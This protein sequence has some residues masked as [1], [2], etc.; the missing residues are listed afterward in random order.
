MTDSTAALRRSLE[1]RFKNASRT[2]GQPSSQIRRRFFHQCYLAR[3]FTLPG[4]DWVLKGGV[5]LAVR[6]SNARH[7]IDIDLYRQGARDELG[8][9]IEQLITA[10]GPS[11]RDPF[12]FEV[13]RKN[14]IIGAAGGTTLTVKCLL[15]TR[16]LDTFPIDLTTRDHTVGQL[17]E[18]T[19]E[20]LVQIPQVMPPPP[21]LV[22]PLADQIADKLAAMY[23][24]HAQGHPSSRYRDLVDLVLI[25]LDDQSIDIHELHRAVTTQQALRNVTIPTPL[26]APGQEWNEQY[27]KLSSSTPGIPQRL[28]RL[29][30]AL[31]H[32]SHHLHD[33][34]LPEQHL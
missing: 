33:A 28:R 12:I 32:V 27:H 22:Y 7:S 26:T 34:L 2:T 31:A 24:I 11:K 21:M 20:H 29:D 3:V 17:E 1:S 16:Q 18:V 25:T 9:S 23:E 19:P 4:N 6:V 30:T 10:G 14:Q 13:T 8:T 15:G 5:G